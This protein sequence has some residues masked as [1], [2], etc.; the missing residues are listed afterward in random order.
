MPERVRER[1]RVQV[2]E[3]VRV[4]EI[5]GGA[6]T[7]PTEPDARNPDAFQQWPGTDCVVSLAG[8]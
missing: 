8:A 1:E 5:D 7:R 4:R 3:R 6:A 2:R